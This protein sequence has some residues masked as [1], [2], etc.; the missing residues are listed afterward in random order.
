MAMIA[1][2]LFVTLF[3]FGEDIVGYRDPTGMVQL[4]LLATFIFGI[5]CGLKV[6]R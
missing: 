5:I 1:M 4:S 2:M 3:A 6:G